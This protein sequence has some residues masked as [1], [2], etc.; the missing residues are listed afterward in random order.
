ML[1]H[2]GVLIPGRRQVAVRTRKSHGRARSYQDSHLRSTRCRSRPRAGHRDRGG[3]HSG[4]RHRRP[5]HRC[6]TGTLPC[7]RGQGA[8]APAASGAPAAA[9]P[10]QPDLAAG[11]GVMPASS[12][13]AATA[14]VIRLARLPRHASTGRAAQTA[15]E[16]ELGDHDS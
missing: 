9:W 4:P 11:T 13:T 16:I 1:G 5:R 12:G 6:I 2:A 15:A 7:A 14:A 8:P 10:A 3:A